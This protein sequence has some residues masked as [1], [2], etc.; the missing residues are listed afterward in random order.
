MKKYLFGFVCSSLLVATATAQTTT[1]TTTA[2]TTSSSSS[3]G[4][5]FSM[6]PVVGAGYTGVSGLKNTKFKV[7][8]DAGLAMVYSAAEHFGI[9]LDVLYSLEG[10]KQDGPDPL[11]VTHTITYNLNLNYIRV[12]LKAIYFF[13]QYGNSVRPKIFV[14]PSFGFLTT[15]KVKSGSYPQTDVKDNAKSTDVGII[16]GVGSNFRLAP[17]TWLNLDL[18]Y[19]QGLTNTYVSGTEDHKNMHAFLNVGVNFGL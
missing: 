18:S 19:T 12:P 1:T 2:T 6:G 3:G 11:D 8:G 4:S 7:G 15:A 14:G 5:K 16:G 9:G 13:N 10:M 17:K